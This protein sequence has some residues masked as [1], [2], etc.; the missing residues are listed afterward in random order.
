MSTKLQTGLTD[1]KWITVRDFHD[2]G[3]GFT[4]P[5]YEA[6]YVTDVDRAYI[7]NEIVLLRVTHSLSD[8]QRVYHL[9][10]AVFEEVGARLQQTQS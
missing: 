7:E 6:K 8:D 10:K 9:P 2:G 4:L 1:D 5:K 3:N